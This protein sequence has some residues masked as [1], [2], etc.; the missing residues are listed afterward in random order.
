VAFD[1]TLSR[2]ELPTAT[3]DFEMNVGAPSGILNRFYGP[4]IIFS[5]RAGQKP[6]EALE[7]RIT[8]GV[9]IATMEIN[10]VSIRFPDLNVRIANRIPFSV[11]DTAGQMC[12]FADGWRYAAIH[13]NQIV[14]GIEWEMVGIKGSFGLCGRAHQLFSKEAGHCKKRTAE[15]Q[16]SKKSA[17]IGQ[18]IGFLHV[19]S[20]GLRCVG[21]IN[22]Y[23][24]QCSSKVTAIIGK[25][26]FS[27]R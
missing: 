13:N 6:T 16:I 4:K 11:K 24:S 21:S 1:I 27:G 14:V 22:R 26:V 25:L 9:L 17:A 3:F 20:F 2:Q 19:R 7:I 5:R 10:A 8:A 15:C 18:C 23:D 12:N